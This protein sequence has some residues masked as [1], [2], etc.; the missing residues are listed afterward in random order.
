[1]T[2]LS[3][4]K[5][6]KGHTV[7]YWNTRSL[8]PR[9]E[10]VQRIM[11]TGSPEL[12][13]L[14]ETWLNSSVDDEQVTFDGYNLIRADRTAE[15]HKKGGGGLAL[16][17]KDKLDCIYLT[18]YTMCTP[19]IECLW[20]GLKLVNTRLIVYGLVYG[21]PSG[22][23]DK[24]IEAIEDICFSLRSQR[25]CEINVG[26]DININVKKRELK[27][28]KYQECLKRMGLTQLITDITHVSDSSLMVSTID[29]FITSDRELYNKVGTIVHGATDHMLVFATRKKEYVKHDNE[30]YHGRAYGKMDI[31]KFIYDVIS[32][33]W[34]NVYTLTDP[35]RACNTFKVKFIS[36]LDTHAPYK[37]FNSRKDR[38]PWVTTEFLECGNERDEKLKISTQTNDPVDKREYKRTRNRVVALKRELKR[39]FF[40]TS[41]QESRGDSKKLWKALKL[42]LTIILLTLDP[43]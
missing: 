39:L 35:D 20:L 33:S 4:L 29:H 10:E 26:G 12:L 34:D 7:I 14:S 3:D 31:P 1:M 30:R 24:F 25:N 21:P 13:G 43:N 28:R 38:Q 8:L 15:S 16:Y 11:D 17:Y 27:S 36:K 9:L 19:D 23:V 2:Q 41:I 32:T 37:F 5:S 22:N 6:F 40:Q 42:K 18:E